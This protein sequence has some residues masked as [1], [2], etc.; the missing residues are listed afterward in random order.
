MREK[1]QH[2]LITTASLFQILALL[3]IWRLQHRQTCLDTPHTVTPVT[4]QQPLSLAMFC[5]F[6][7][8]WRNSPNR[9]LSE[10]FLRFTVRTQTWRD[11]MKEWSAHR[12]GCYLHNKH[13]RRT[14]LG[15][16]NQATPGLRLRPHGYRD[17]YQTG[18][19]AYLRSS[20]YIRVNNVNGGVTAE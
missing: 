6:S 17:R 14:T 5:H 3:I 7:F 1:K 15:R 18:I 13:K 11:P 16:R 20:Q 8:L 9:A 4:T 2:L 12:K 10:Q 19:T